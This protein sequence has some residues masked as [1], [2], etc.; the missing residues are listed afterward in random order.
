MHI[1]AIADPPVTVTTKV[2][3]TLGAFRLIT[4]SKQTPTNPESSAAMN[5]VSIN[6]LGTAAKN[7]KCLYLHSDW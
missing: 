3:K 4:I 1:P 6:P 7:K 2:P 5:D